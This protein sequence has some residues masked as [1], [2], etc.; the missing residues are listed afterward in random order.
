M[1]NTIRFLRIAGSLRKPSYTRDISF[2]DSKISL[3]LNY[4]HIIDEQLRRSCARLL[5][6]KKS[7]D[8]LEKAAKNRKRIPLSILKRIDKEKS[9]VILLE[10]EI[11]NMLEIESLLT[12][13]HYTNKE[14]LAALKR[15][16][17]RNKE[18]IYNLSR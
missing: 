11:K 15:A 3:S 8:K 12:D 16:L 7:V 13:A 1:Y 10:R 2:L 18:I 17:E 5:E 6:L 4:Q 14:D 9:K